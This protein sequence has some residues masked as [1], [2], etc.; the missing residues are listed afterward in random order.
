MTGTGRLTATV[1]RRTQRILY[2]EPVPVAVSDELQLVSTVDLAHVVMLT[3]RRLLDRSDAALL[4]RHILLLRRADFAPLHRVPTPR[5]L[6]LAYE[7][8][9]IQELGAAAGGR[10]HTARSRN[11]L[12]A[13]TTVMRLRTRVLDL[14]G[15]LARLQAVLLCRARAHRDTVMPVYTHFQAAEPVTYGY[16]LTGMALALSREIAAVRYAADGLRASPLGAGAVAGTDL[17]VDCQRT[18][19][20]LG[21]DAPPVHALDA[22]ASRDVPLRVLASAAGAALTLSRLATDLQLWSTAEFGFVWFPDRLVGGSSALPQK[23]NAFLLE[24]VKAKAGAAIGAW[25]AAAS[26]VKSVPFTNSIE[27]GTEAMAPLWPGL[28]AVGDAVQLAQ[29][30]VSGARPVPDRMAG[31]AADGFVTATAA[32]N[33]LVRRGVPFR[34]AHRLVGQSV[35]Q[36][37]EQGDTRLSILD[38][39]DGAGTVD[40]GGLTPRG[41]AAKRRWGGGPGAFDDGFGAARLALGEHGSW[42]AALRDR[43]RA[44]DDRLCRAVAGIAGTAPRDA[45]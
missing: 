29:V 20:L 44:A 27:V 42:C 15:E 26:A 6:Y 18:A 4:L 36:A 23:R 17:P 16:Y 45:A 24:H 43:V 5:G 11:D 2:G 22:V 7:D 37:L 3:E 19:E 32:A 12:K 39:P 10:L 40:V 13:A 21:F 31:R 35:R 30:L 28:D 1:G 9:L 34:T 41:V 38:L 8:H 25:T 14:V 33:L